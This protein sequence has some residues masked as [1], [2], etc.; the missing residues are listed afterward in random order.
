MLNIRENTY[1]SVDCERMDVDVIVIC[2]AAAA[3]AARTHAHTAMCRAMCLALLVLFVINFN[4]LI[5]GHTQNTCAHIDTIDER[6]EPSTWTLLTRPMQMCMRRRTAATLKFNV[7]KQ[8]IAMLCVFYVAIV[9]FFLVIRLFFF[10]VTSVIYFQCFSSLQFC[11]GYKC[12]FED[13]I[14]TSKIR[15][16][17]LKKYFGIMTSERKE[18]KTLHTGQGDFRG[19]SCCCGTW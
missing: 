17:K 6:D 14:L 16:R 4:L 1:V 13:A 19:R 3:A 9:F 8:H 18:G 7:N 12:P 10:F 2:G 5:D 15:F 11:I